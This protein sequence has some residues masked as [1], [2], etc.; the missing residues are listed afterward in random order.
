MQSLSPQDHEVLFLSPRCACAV[1]G[2]KIQKWGQLSR[3]AASHVAWLVFVVT[4]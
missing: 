4:V 3:V 1:E 2:Q